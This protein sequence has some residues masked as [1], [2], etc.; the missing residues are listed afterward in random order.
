MTMK[1]PQYR[2]ALV[3]LSIAAWVAAGV[4]S[5]AR[6]EEAVLV[7]A[8][9]GGF[10]T[11][12]GENRVRVSGIQGT[13]AVRTGKDGELRYEVRTLDNRREERP[14][15]LWLN[16]RAFELGPLEDAADERLLLEIAVPPGL[17]VELD[18]DD[19]NIQVGGLRSDLVVVG[20]RLD[21]DLR[22]I[23]GHTLIEVVESGGKING[24]TGD[25]DIDSE[26]VSLVM[27]QVDGDLSLTLVDSEADVRTVTGHADIDLENTVMVISEVDDGIVLQA[28]GGSAGIHGVKREI[29][30]RLD[31]TALALSGLTGRAVIESDSDIQFEGLKTTM[32]ITGY[33]G[34]IR[35][36]GSEGTLEITVDQAMV[37][38]EEI[39]GKLSISGHDLGVTIKDVAAETT[40]RTENSEVR[41]EKAEAPLHI[42]NGL[43]L[44]EVQGATAAVKVVNR[45]A[46]VKLSEIGGP[47]DI[48]ASG[49]FVEVGWTEIPAEGNQVIVNER[50]SIV[51]NLPARGRCR[52]EAQSKYGTIS[53]DIPTVRI[54]DDGRFA[55]GVI[56]GGRG[57]TIQVRSEGDVHLAAGSGAKAPDQ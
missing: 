19:S 33:G 26:A 49:E 21:I 47:V 11:L 15:G 4:G 22:G 44:V 39:K 16:G 14:I 2:T 6:A 30:L 32:N 37:E 25:V 17:P 38:L 51:L 7:H 41:I 53:S 28:S 3:A 10:I 48:Y 5:T 55:S 40:I 8:E 36:K 29:D 50:G 43:G 45:D 20:A 57:P 27:D 9:S 56:G 42:D 12:E 46:D 1:P 23:H 34:S 52:I 13:V 24:M 31:G 54:N 18:L 35:G